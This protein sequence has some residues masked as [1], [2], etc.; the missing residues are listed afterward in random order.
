[1]SNYHLVVQYRTWDAE[2][3]T[4]EMPAEH[5]TRDRHANKA[6][7][8]ADSLNLCCMQVHDVKQVHQRIDRG[9]MKA[10]AKL[11]WNQKSRQLLDAFEIVS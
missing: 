9:R 8:Q 3:H 10:A 5:H 7:C 1:M 4:G 11:D 6:Y 2:Q